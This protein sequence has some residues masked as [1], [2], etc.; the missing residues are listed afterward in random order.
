MGYP[1]PS[2]DSSLPMWGSFP[3]C[4]WAV[5]FS[6]C[7]RGPLEVKKTIHRE[8]FIIEIIDT[9]HFSYFKRRVVVTMLNVGDKRKIAALKILEFTT[10]VIWEYM[11]FKYGPKYAKFEIWLHF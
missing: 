9:C 5:I 6:A 11:I 7:A 8:I 2:L 3:Q 4:L 1:T 10:V